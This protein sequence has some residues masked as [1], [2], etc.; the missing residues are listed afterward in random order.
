MQNT[1]LI[2]EDTFWVGANDT[3]LSL[4]ENIFPVPNGIAYNSYL[5][6]DEKTVLLDTVD[7]S[8]GERYLENVQHVLQGRTLDYLIINHM[9]PDHCATIEQIVKLYPKIQL[10]CNAKTVS[11]IKQFYSF[12]VEGNIIVVKEGDKLSTGKHEFSFYFAPMVHW[13]EVMV[14][15]DIFS[16]ALYTADAFGTFGA[17]EG[18]L[19]AD[20]T[21]YSDDFINEARRYYTNIVGKYG[22]Q[23]S[24]LLKKAS[25]LPINYICPLHGPVWR[26]NISFFIEKYAKWAKYEPEEK[27][28]VIVYASI[29]GNTENAVQILASKLVEKG[30]KA[31]NLYDVSGVDASYIISQAFKYSHLVFASVTYNAAVFPKLESLLSELKHHNF[32]NRTVSIIE[33]GSW[34]ITC[35]KLML[36]TLQSMKNMNVLQT[37]VSI[38]SSVKQENYNQLEIMAGEIVKSINDET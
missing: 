6:T 15:Y 2:C 8:V 13:P 21:N 5:I 22:V 29:Y 30:V 18:K 38:M 25:A 1:R 26:E 16:K 3:R 28:V 24:A 9:E 10:V 17:H 34:A 7:S 19:F 35:G 37:K 14:T 33:N 12:N 32:Q 27:G 36:E 23:V 20:E 11:M 31:V 4:F